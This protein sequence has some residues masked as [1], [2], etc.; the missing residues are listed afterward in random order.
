MAD[1]RRGRL[2]GGGEG[3]S[4][5]DPSIH[6]PVLPPR[7]DPLAPWQTPALDPLQEAGDLEAIRDAVNPSIADELAVVCRLAFMAEVTPWKELLG[8]DVAMKWGGPLAVFFW[9]GGRGGGL[10]RVCILFFRFHFFCPQGIVSTRVVFFGR[11]TWEQRAIAR[12]FA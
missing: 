7:T 8:R 9:G 2:P 10:Q 5:F 12:V 1:I 11:K 4:D 3:R 6:V